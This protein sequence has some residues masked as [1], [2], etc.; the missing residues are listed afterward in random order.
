MPI[1]TNDLVP[2]LEWLLGPQWR[3]GA[4]FQ[5]IVFWP[6]VL[7]A[8]LALG[9]LL[10]KLRKGSEAAHRRVGR[11]AALAL[12]ALAAA[13]G[14]LAGAWWLFGAGEAAGKPALV[15]Y[16]VSRLLHGATVLLGAQ[17]YQGSLYLWLP[18]VAGLALACLVVGSLA[19][20]LRGGLGYA[21]RTV[22]DALASLVADLAQLSARRTWALSRL[23]VKEAIRRSIVVVFVVFLVVLLFAGWFI[24]PSNPN[25]ARLYMDLVL[26]STGYLTLFL[27]MFLSALSLPAD[28]KNRTIHTVVTKPVRSSEIVLGRIVGFTVVGTMLLGAMGVLSYVFVV[29]GVSH[30]HEL[31]AADLHAVGPVVPGEAPSLRGYTG[32]ARNHQHEVTVDSQGNVRVEMAQGHWHEV[33]V[34][35][36]G[37]GAR[38]TLGPPQGMLLARVPLYGKLRFKN[39]QGADVERGVNV[40]DEWVYR[41]F[42]EGGGRAAAIWTFE[43]I[44]EAE[45][46]D[47]LPV[48]MTIEI[49]RTYKGDIEHGVPGALLVRRPD[50]HEKPVEVRIFAAKKFA[51]DVQFIPRYF[52]Y[53]TGRKGD[54]KEEKYDLFRDFVH[55]GKLEIWLQCVPPAQYFGMAQADLYVRHPQDSWFWLNFAK[56]YFGIW[57][58]MVLVIGMGVMFSTFLSGSVA[59]LA[60]LAASVAAFF[61][62][63][64]AEV[65]SGKLVGGGPLESI[66]RIVTQQN[67]TS[68]LAP[69][70][71]TTAIKWLDP[72]LGWPM[73][74]IAALLPDFSRF[75]FADY[76]SYGF[77]VNGDVLLQCVARAAAFLLPVFV[78]GYLFLK[79]REVAE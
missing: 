33:T 59:L 13:A 50:S 14:G 76:V 70:L 27:A 44:N 69:G 4:L 55:E 53:S 16:C 32:M 43:G 23:A 25:P 62:D 21:A 28:I 68:E 12:L 10:V 71:R 5:P 39:N 6:L 29:R 34:E 38:Y 20:L 22:D 47:G 35:G 3:L 42:I 2:F 64:L 18:L 41:S 40:G 37:K 75:N 78:V 72:V 60:T 57:L 65:A 36:S 30:T 66:D 8:A 67:M 77:T 26:T 45:F 1:E 56:G 9:W 54:K 15:D 52:T 11:G 51:T 63:F 73:G 24:D 17:W 46:P 48:E 31:K 61:V 74:V 58:L 49:F 19:A 7:V 79:M